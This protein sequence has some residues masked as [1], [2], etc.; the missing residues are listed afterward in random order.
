[1]TYPPIGHFLEIVFEQDQRVHRMAAW[2]ERRH[3]VAGTNF[4]WIMGAQ[5]MRGAS[6]GS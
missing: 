4:N 6:A 1:L 2:A 3:V 5:A